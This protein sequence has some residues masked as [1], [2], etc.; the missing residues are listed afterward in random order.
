[1]VVSDITDLHDYDRFASNGLEQCPMC[2]RTIGGGHGY[3]G[4]VFDADGQEFESIHDTDPFEGP[5]YCR[6][7]YAVDYQSMIHR[8]ITAFGE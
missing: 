6:E 1:M 8:D 7:C 2:G 5:Y 4:P 3:H